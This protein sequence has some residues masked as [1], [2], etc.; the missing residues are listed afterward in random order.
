V[1]QAGDKLMVRAFS[2]TQW[3]ALL[4]D[5]GYPKTPPMRRP[6]PAPEPVKSPV[7]QPA[8]EPVGGGYPKN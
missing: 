7:A 6:A 8:A 1:L 2:D 3:Q 5:A 4:D